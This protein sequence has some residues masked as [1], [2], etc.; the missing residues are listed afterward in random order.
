MN[1]WINQALRIQSLTAQG[2]WR[3]PDNDSIIIARGGGSQA[4][5]GD[6]ANLF[7]PDVDILCCTVKP[8]KLLL[9]DGSTVTQI[10]KS[11][12]LPNLQLPRGTRNSTAAR[13]I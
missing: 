7:V 11:V 4:G 10:V 3:F 12:R 8:Q 6:G 2:D 5:G 13:R 1:E 9:N